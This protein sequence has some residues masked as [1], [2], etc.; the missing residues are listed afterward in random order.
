MNI[1]KTQRIVVAPKP[2]PV[3]APPTPTPAR[4]PVPA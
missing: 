4:E 1:G 3:P 2:E